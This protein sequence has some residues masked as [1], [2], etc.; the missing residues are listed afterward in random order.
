MADFKGLGSVPIT[1]ISFLTPHPLFS[2]AKVNIWWKPLPLSAFFFFCA[3]LFSPVLN[4]GFVVVQPEN[5]L[6]VDVKRQRYAN[7]RGMFYATARYPQVCLLHGHRP[8]SPDGPFHA[9]TA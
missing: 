5:T 8:H 6:N 9:T 4:G 1:Q 7:R 2:R 3:L